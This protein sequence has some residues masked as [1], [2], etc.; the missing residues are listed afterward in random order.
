MKVYISIDG[1]L[2]NFI[3]RYHYHYENAFINV[4][5]D[6]GDTFEYKVTEPITNKNLT[7]HFLFQSKEQ[8]DYFQ[9]IEY[10]MELYGH[11]PVSYNNVNNDLNRL[12]HHHKDHEICLVGLDELG[13]ARP[14]TFFFLS[15]NGFMVNNV[16]FIRSD[17]IEKEWLE[18]DLWIS[19]SE[20]VLQHKPENKEFI[21]FATNYN[22]HFTYEKI[23]HKLSDI[24][25]ENDIIVINEET[26]KLLD[27]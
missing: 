13:K 14:S 8:E 21:L 12:V 5:E 6:N 2:R 10:P 27:A 11:A 25:I 4:D 16:K 7:N 20:K 24:N 3:N 17:E 9:Y 23:I 19:D 18:A 22:Q 26:Q 1:V 15:R